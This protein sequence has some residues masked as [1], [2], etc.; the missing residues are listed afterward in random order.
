MSTYIRRI[1]YGFLGV[2][3]IVSMGWSLYKQTTNNFSIEETI[4]VSDLEKKYKEVLGQGGVMTSIPTVLII[5]KI[6]VSASIE[7]VGIDKEGLM[8]VPKKPENVGWLNVSRVPGERGVAIIDG[9][10]GWRQRRPVVFDEL[11]QLTVGDSVYVIND[12]GETISFIVKKTKT[13]HKDADASEVF[14][15]QNSTA[16]LNLVT[17]SG[18]WDKLLQT[19]S[20][21][22]VVFTERV[23]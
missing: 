5:P 23:Q 7:Q 17:C 4:K 3:A 10:R 20:E 6:N 13:Y 2:V 15:S 18:F 14:V 11:H 8:D 22:F 21:R 12:Q 9:H 1:F 16:Q 19:S